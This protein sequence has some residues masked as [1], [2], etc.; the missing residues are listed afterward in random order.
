LDTDASRDG[1]VYRVGVSNCN[2]SR[3]PGCAGSRDSTSARDRG[4]VTSVELLD[5][6][7]KDLGGDAVVNYTNWSTSWLTKVWAYAGADN[8]SIMASIATNT[9]TFLILYLLFSSLLSSLMCRSLVCV[10]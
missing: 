7:V 4:L 10:P 8:T 9:I 3:A 5:A 6:Y 2:S 1:D